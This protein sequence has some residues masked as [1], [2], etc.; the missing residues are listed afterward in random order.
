MAGRANCHEASIF[1]VSAELVTKDDA[2][3][4]GLDEMKVA[5]ANADGS[6][7]D[8]FAFTRWDVDVFNGNGTLRGVHS[9]HGDTVLKI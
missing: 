6:D 5:A 8:E 9:E 2:R 1:G 4:A 7:S 3:E